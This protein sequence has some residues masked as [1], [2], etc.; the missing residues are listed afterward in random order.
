MCKHKDLSDFDKNQKT[1]ARWLGLSISQ[2]E[3]LV[4]CLHM[5]V[6]VSTYQ[7]RSKEGQPVSWQQ[8]HGYTR[9]INAYGEWRLSCLVWSHRGATVAEIA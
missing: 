9:L 5:Y 8:G 1:M 7:K 6:V 4:W 3:G 2:M